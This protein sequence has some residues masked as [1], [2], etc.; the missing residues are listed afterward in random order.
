MET[1]IVRFIDHVPAA[2]SCMAATPPSCAAARPYL[3]VA[4]ANGDIEL[5]LPDNAWYP[6]RVILGGKNRAVSALAWAHQSVLTDPELWD[7]DME[8][9]MAL[10]RITNRKPRLFASSLNGTITEW[11]IDTLEPVKIMDASGGGVWSLAVNPTGTLLAAGCD[12][13]CIRVYDIADDEFEHHRTFQKQQ[14]RV[15]CV[16][17]H[18]TGDF[19]VSGSDDS[20]IRQWTVSNGA[21]R[22]RS[23][24]DRVNRKNT[25]VWA[26]RV[27]TDGTV[28]AGTSLGTVEWWDWNTATLIKSVKGHDAD[29]LALDVSRDGTE[30][31]SASIDRGVAQYRIAGASDFASRN[32]KGNSAHAKVD[33]HKWVR[34]AMRR[35]HS[36]DVKSILVVETSSGRFIVSGGVDTELTI[37]NL[38]PGGFTNNPQRRHDEFEVPRVAIAHRKDWLLARFETSLRLYKLGAAAAATQSDHVS[39]AF[40]QQ[41]SVE[42]APAI[43]AEVQFSDIRNIAQATISTDGQWIVAAHHAATKLWFVDQGPTLSHGSD[44]RVV[45]ARSRLPYLRHLATAVPRTTIGPARAGVAAGSCLVVGVAP[46]NVLHVYLLPSTSSSSKSEQPW[47]PVHLAALAHHEGRHVTHV[48]LS[49]C[50]TYLVSAD[51]SAR[52]VL[53]DLAA[54]LAAAPSS[55]SS[56]GS[57]P[58]DNPLFTQ[59]TAQQHPLPAHAPRVLTSL[60]FIAQ[61]E[62]HALRLTATLDNHQLLVHDAPSFAPHPWPRTNMSRLGRDVHERADYFR[63]VLPLASGPERALAWTSNWFL[64][65]DFAR[66]LPNPAKRRPSVSSGT[67]TTPAV[68]ADPALAAALA[69]ATEGD[70]V[71]ALP[72]PIPDEPA[73]E[74]GGRGYS[75]LARYQRL[76][77]VDMFDSGRLVVVERPWVDVAETL[78]AAFARKRYGM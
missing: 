58:S 25:L 62:H 59:A 9:E 64:A 20:V 10:R 11:D 74:A 72:L 65:I 66:D 50:G 40:L 27:L 42:N 7:D 73:V 37:V 12:D 71:D 36:N 61:S 53:V 78:P 6:E 28:V 21:P 54:S 13:G 33:H 2:I 3:A 31:Y 46:D 51:A 56:N 44:V 26:I 39:K 77:H 57:T 70:L 14:G 1:H 48:A 67:T 38:V 43:L 15:L 41:L 60:Q 29:V 8:R 18:P 68:E 32:R 34:A 69:A 30:V 19:L 49:P 52:I 55:S 23:T 63:G 16:A 45:R 35:Y 24:L 5:R 76:M 22:D 47:R 4:R 75:L 17:W